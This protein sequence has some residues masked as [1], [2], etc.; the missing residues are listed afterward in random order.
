MPP[1]RFSLWRGMYPA[2]RLKRWL[3]FT[4]IGFFFLG[5][6]MAL[7]MVFAIFAIPGNLETAQ[8]FFPIGYLATSLLAACSGWLGSSPACA[9]RCA[10]SGATAPTPRSG[11][12][13]CS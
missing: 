4:W 11:C 10:S 13:T 7:G 1:S 5:L 12:A 6:A 3:L 2:V 9:G 8:S